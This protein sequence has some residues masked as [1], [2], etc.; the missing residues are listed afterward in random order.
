QYIYDTA[1]KVPVGTIQPNFMGGLLVSLRYKN[2]NL[3]TQVDGRF[4]GYVYSEAY[5]YAMSQGTPLIS[6]KYR[7]QAH[8]GVAL[9]NPYTGQT[10]YDG[11]VPNAVFGPGSVGNTSAKA[12][13]T[14]IAGMTFKQAYDQGL[15]QPW[16]VAAYYDGSPG[17][18][19]TYDWENGIN[20]NGAIS[21]E[22]W[23]M[24][25][26]ISLSYTLPEDIVRKT[27]VLQGASLTLSARNIGYLYN[28]LPDGQNPAS[29][30]SNNPLYPYLTGGIPFIR[31]YSVRLDVKF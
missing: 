6:L 13:Q 14:S 7:D 9:T 18:N 26:E 24:L 17:F 10:E 23:V 27:H 1:Q 28:S 30:M 22:T 2:F 15:V 25:R 19:G 16:Y 3:F 21:K 12:A 31:N 4:G 5:T 8:G 11:A 29:V 20:Y